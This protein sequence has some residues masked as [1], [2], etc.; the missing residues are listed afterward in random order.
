MSKKSCNFAALFNR[1]RMRE[2]KDYI[3]AKY[4]ERKKLSI[5]KTLYLFKWKKTRLLRMITLSL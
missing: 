4:V 2:K 1:V 3:S 5:N